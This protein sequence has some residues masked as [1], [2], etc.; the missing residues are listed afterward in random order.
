MFDVLVG[1]DEDD[2]YTVTA[3]VAGVLAGGNY[4]ENLDRN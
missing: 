2:P 3:V 1:F 4:A